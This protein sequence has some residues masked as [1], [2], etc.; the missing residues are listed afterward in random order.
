[1]EQSLPETEESQAVELY[2]FLYRDQNRLASYYAQVFA[3]RLSLTEETDQ[4]R[5]GH[6]TSGKGGIHIVEGTYQYEND[7]T[8]SVKRVVDPHDLNTIGILS[9]LSENGMIASDIAEAGN[10]DMVRCRGTLILIDGLTN[11]DMLAM[12]A[13]SNPS[14]NP[15][16]KYL[17][18]NSPEKAAYEEHMFQ[19]KLVKDWLSNARL[20]SGFVLANEQ[21][22]LLCGTLHDEGMAEPIHSYYF[23]HGKRGLNDVYIIGIKEDYDTVFPFLEEGN[24]VFDASGGFISAMEDLMFPTDGIRVTPLVMFR[25]LNQAKSTRLLSPANL[26]V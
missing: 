22:H 10:G 20:P 8:S 4:K 6:R 21:S 23:K 24:S 14:L 18:K 25:I 15:P 16:Q 2:D 12:A 19:A 13:A 5:S 1:M 11:R 9:Y 3:G 17:S 7:A 26:P